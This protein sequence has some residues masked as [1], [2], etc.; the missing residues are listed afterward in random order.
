M[1]DLLLL[2][3]G[4]DSI[5]IAAWCRPEVCLTVDYGQ[6]PAAAEI[7]SAAEVCRR[8]GLVHDVI[9]VPISQLG[10]GV[11]AGRPMAEVS[12]YEEFWPFRNQFLL[13]LA[14]MYAVSRSLRRVLIGT[15]RN[16]NRH[17]D[18][19]LAFV[20]QI[21]QLVAQQ[22]GHITLVVPAIE[23]TTVELV[24]TSNIDQSVLGWAHSCHTSVVACGHCPGCNK[25]FETMRD[26]GWNL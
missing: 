15:V 7:D 8:L 11:L 18:G 16:D 22:E 5:A 23:L 21:A 9:R 19:S 20:A 26:L 14:A 1:S 25:H 24:K 12:P 13:T 4:I 17:S 6:L 2:S 10:S 3:G